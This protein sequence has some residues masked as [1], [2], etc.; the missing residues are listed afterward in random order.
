MSSPD[1]TVMGPDDAGT[2]IELFDGITAYPTVW[3][4]PDPDP[5]PVEAYVHFRPGAAYPVLD[6]HL[7]SSETVLVLDGVL[8]DENGT[9]VAGTRIHG[10]RGSQHTPRSDTGAL[11]YVIFPDRIPDTGSTKPVH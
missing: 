8:Q 6:Q 7:D 11:L 9:Y 10:R 4:V 1:F 3:S 5:L 2:P